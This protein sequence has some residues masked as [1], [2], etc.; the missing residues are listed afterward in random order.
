MYSGHDT[1][2]S[3]SGKQLVEEQ[4]SIFID[5]IPERVGQELRQTLKNRLTPKGEP[6]KVRYRLKVHLS[7]A[8]LAEQGVQLDNLATRYELTY[9]AHYTLY[10][11][12]ENKVLLR[13][14]S[15]SRAS[16]DVQ[17]SPYASY[18]AEQKMKSRVMR[19]LGD[20]ISLRLAAYLKSKHP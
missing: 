14:E 15:V 17:P 3:V 5:E 7:E 13:D 12:P 9:T 4:A 2:S 1:A 6:K 16:Y 19:I 10:S 18:A 8:S 11:Y 20:D